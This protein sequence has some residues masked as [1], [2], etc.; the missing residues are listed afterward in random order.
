MEARAGYS[1]LVLAGLEA[2]AHAQGD[3][4]PRQTA[5][6]EI[7]AGL[8]ARAFSM[9]QGGEP[10]LTPATLGHI[11]RGLVRDG[12]CV[13]L[14][15]PGE[16]LIPVVL[17]NVTGGPEES[18]WRYQVDMVGPTS[19][20]TK[21]VPGDEVLHFR[22]AYR[23]TEPWRGVAPWQ[24]ARETGQTA[25]NVERT[26][27]QEA[28]IP[29]S[30]LLHSFRTKTDEEMDWLTRKLKQARGTLSVIGSDE[31]HPHTGSGEPYKASRIGSE[32]P[33]ELNTLRQDSA[34]Q[35]LAACGVHPAL[36]GIERGE[37]AATRE[38]WRQF[39]YATVQPVARLV[40]DEMRHKLATKTSLGFDDL[41]A[42][43]IQGRARAHAALVKSGM[44]QDAAGRHTG[45]T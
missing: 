17:T 37:A 22:Y 36:V 4:D 9:A 42:S 12:E 20:V 11:A 3:C 18:T 8:W 15:S 41:A 26:A 14:V 40:E 7:A 24:W 25:G 6:I 43:D 10:Y 32:M 35:I 19:T 30:Y 27:K 33:G 13:C 31:K 1:D 28:G 29:T 21:D 39:L 45:I 34:V 16:A 2:Q 44:S 38:V 23:A 5:A